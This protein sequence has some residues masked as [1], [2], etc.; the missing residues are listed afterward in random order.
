V[1]LCCVLLVEG[2]F[3]DFD[4]LKISRN[5]RCVSLARTVLEGSAD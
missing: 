2:V 5:C 4:L 3:T 1:I